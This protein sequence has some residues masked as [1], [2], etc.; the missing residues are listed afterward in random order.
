M[1]LTTIGVIVNTHGLKGTLR[2]KSFTDFKTERYA[3]G[4][5][6][7]IDFRNELIP[8]TVEKFKSVKTLEHIDFKE[9]TDINQCEKYKGS[10]LKMN[11]EMAHDLPE[12]EFYFDE[13]LNMEVYSEALIGICVDI[14]EVPKGELIVVKR[15]GK[16]D[17]LIPFNKEFI[18][19]VDKENNK[20]YIHEWEGLL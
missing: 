2:V 7:Y 20:I 13:L 9:F 15:E 10:E 3:K 11:A 17:V 1:E 12:D 8:V 18:K 4:N 14:R 6:L 5:T 16:K 19:E